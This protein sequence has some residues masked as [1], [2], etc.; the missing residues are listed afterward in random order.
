MSL[1][2]I[3]LALITMFAGAYMVYHLT[4][5]SGDDD[6]KQE[7]VGA[8]GGYFH[9]AHN[10]SVL[11]VATPADTGGHTTECAAGPMVSEYVTGISDVDPDAPVYCEK[12]KR[13]RKNGKIVK[14][15]VINKSP[16]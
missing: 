2:Y 9:E 10:K 4:R 5:K 14:G 8:T 15:P 12:L 1:G 16:V 11:N 7:V 3:A 6:D 13:W